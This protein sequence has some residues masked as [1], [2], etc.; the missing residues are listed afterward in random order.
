MS[1]SNFMGCVCVLPFKY[2]F[3]FSLKQKCNTNMPFYKF[4]VN[5]VYFLGVLFVFWLHGMLPGSW[6]AVYLTNRQPEIS[7]SSVKVCT[8]LCPKVRPLVTQ[9]MRWSDLRPLCSWK[10]DSLTSLTFGDEGSAWQADLG[11]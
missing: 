10:S 5:L 4:F 9:Q 3:F 6:S 8:R 1:T 11:P 2:V 7:S